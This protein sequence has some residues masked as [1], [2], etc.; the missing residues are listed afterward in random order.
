MGPRNGD[1]REELFVAMRRMGVEVPPLSE[2]KR[3]QAAQLAAEWSDIGP[4]S[5]SQVCDVLAEKL[6]RRKEKQNGAR[7][8]NEK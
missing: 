6:E 7:P 5:S 8:M 4:D 1:E 2:D 3:G